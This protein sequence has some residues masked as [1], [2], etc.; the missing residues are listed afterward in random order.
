MRSKHRLW[1]CVLVLCVGLLLPAT[2]QAGPYIGDFG[3]CWKPAKECPKGEYSFLH[4]WTP[5]MYRAIYHFLPA[6]LDQYPPGLPVA[7]S[8]QAVPSACRTEAPIP[9][10]EYA[11]PAGFFGRP[12]LPEATDDKD[13]K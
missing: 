4:Y 10:P 3:Y 1:W 13:K 8:W 7:L 2:S 9:T 6:H 11:D 12:V 5:T